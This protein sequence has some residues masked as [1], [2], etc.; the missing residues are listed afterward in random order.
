MRYSKIY[1]F[2]REPGKPVE[3]INQTKDGKKGVWTI[4]FNEE[5]KTEQN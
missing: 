1:V 5:G 3:W 4:R 2:M